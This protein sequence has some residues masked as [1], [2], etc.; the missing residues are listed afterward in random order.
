MLGHLSIGV[1]DLT[2]AMRFYDAAM[3]LI[4]WVRIWTSPE[5]VG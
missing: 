3:Q 1:R 5:G 4:G 2:A